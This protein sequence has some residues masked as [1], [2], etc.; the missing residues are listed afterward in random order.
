MKKMSKQLYY[1][2]RE[3]K[4]EAGEARIPW[5]LGVRKDAQRIFASLRETKEMLEKYHP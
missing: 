4:I 5:L 1:I 2:R 3:I